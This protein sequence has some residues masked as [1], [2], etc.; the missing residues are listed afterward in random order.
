MITKEKLKYLKPG[1]SEFYACIPG[2]LL[3]AA[4]GGFEGAFAVAAA[5]YGISTLGR[6]LD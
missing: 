2:G 4:T 3:G 6:L 1:T 5:V